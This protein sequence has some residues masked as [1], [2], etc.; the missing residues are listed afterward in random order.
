M[1]I[2][3]DRYLLLPSLGF[4]LAV[5]F[6]ATSI[7]SARA[8]RGLIAVLVL[9]AALRTLDAKSS[10]RDGESLWARAVESNPA[11]GEAWSAYAEAVNRTGNAER[12]E[13]IVA[14]GLTHVRPGRL[15]MRGALLRLARGDAEGGRALMR[16]ASDAGEPRAMSNLSLLLLATNPDE[17]LA[18]G[19]K[20]A[21]LMPMYAPARRAAGKV[22][23]ATGHAAAAEIEFRRAHDLEPSCTNAYNLALALLQLEHRDE[24]RAFLEPCRGDSALGHQIEAA[25]HR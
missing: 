15:L 10:W 5:A 2:V 13:Q 19:R 17:A 25:L 6:A 18:L 20:G 23:L 14:E 16:E 12:A 24:A 21:Q 4:C 22:E 9:A 3:A 8:R 1:I 11:A 7:S